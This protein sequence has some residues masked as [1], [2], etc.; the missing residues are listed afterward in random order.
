MASM[1]YY[2]TAKQ[3]WDYV[4][5]LVFP[6]GGSGNSVQIGEKTSY[7]NLA[8]MF[9]AL[10]NGTAATGEFIL[11]ETLPNT[12]T[13]IFD[14]GLSNIDG[15]FYVD[16]DY[17]YPHAG[18]ANVNTPEYGVWGFYMAN[19]SGA[20]DITAAGFS[21]FNTTSRWSLSSYNS[22]QNSSFIIR[23]SYRI[24]GG[25]LYV[26]ANYNKHTSYT[27]FWNN[28]KYKWVAWSNS[29]TSGGG[30]TG[31]SGGEEEIYYTSYSG[32]P[33][34]RRVV[35]PEGDYSL[36]PAL[37]YATEMEHYEIHDS[38]NMVST[39]YAFGYCSKLKTVIL[40]TTLTLNGNNR[41][42]QNCTALEAVQIGGIG[43]P[44]A[45]MN[46]ANIFAGCTQ[47]GLTITVY[48]NATSLAGLPSGI[49][50]S[51]WGATNAT[52]VYRN[53]TTGEVLR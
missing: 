35:V 43:R 41:E 40:D 39:A 30:N 34:I 36:L 24:D 22:S 32:A 45:T 19:P 37:R 14:S 28:H 2:N 25:K 16:C 51:P 27:P 18:T 21:T 29:D 33:Y 53:S 3:M 15:I 52:I 44:I 4:N 12:E 7:P 6:S 1:K 50:N 9:Y 42:F 8:N 20:P 49:S 10:E 48:V 5:T 13:L 17:D 26:T 31:G 47:T 46:N 38:G 11:T 23:G